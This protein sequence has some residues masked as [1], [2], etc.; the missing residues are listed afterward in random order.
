MASCHACDNKVTALNDRREG[1]GQDE[2]NREGRKGPPSG[3][4]RDPHNL[5]QCLL[6]TSLFRVNDFLLW[7][8]EKDLSPCQG[9]CGPGPR[10]PR[11]KARPREEE[12]RGPRPP[13]ISS[14]LEDVFSFHQL[15][16]WQFSDH[17]TCSVSVDVWDVGRNLCAW[18]KIT[19]LHII[20]ESWKP[21][22]ATIG[23]WLKK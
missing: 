9:K 3:T 17:F 2:Q 7:K 11:G 10:Q 5:Q 13:P 4:I 21:E 18:M 16:N 23:I 12:A 20:L 19:E 14:N 6:N 8:P 15:Q 1:L 22:Y